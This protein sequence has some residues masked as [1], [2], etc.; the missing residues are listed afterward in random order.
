MWKG[1][2]SVL[3]AANI[4]EQL[5]DVYITGFGSDFDITK[6]TVGCLDPH[7]DLFWQSYISLVLWQTAKMICL[8]PSTA[9]QSLSEIRF[10]GANRKKREIGSLLRSHV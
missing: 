1:M 3:W 5:Y 4:Q 6:E 7:N 2:L 10:Q 9:I 8:S